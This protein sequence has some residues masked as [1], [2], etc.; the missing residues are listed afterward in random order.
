MNTITYLPAASPKLEKAISGKN[1]IH[2]FIGWCDTQEPRRLMWTGIILPAQACIFAPLTFIVAMFAGI[3][4]ALFIPVIAVLVITFISNL[5]ALPT[6]I[7]IPVFISGILID[8]TIMI[9]ALTMGGSVER[10]F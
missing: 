3:H 7:T 10:L 4:F 8:I 1:I 2:R 6:K 9:V 5:A